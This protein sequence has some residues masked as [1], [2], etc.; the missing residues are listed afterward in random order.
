MVVYLIII[1]KCP[2][3]YLHSNLKD[4]LSFLKAVLLIRCVSSTASG[5]TPLRCSRYT[6]RNTA[7]KISLCVLLFLVILCSFAT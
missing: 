5:L 4:F 2:S 1:Y 3:V 6:L 7:L